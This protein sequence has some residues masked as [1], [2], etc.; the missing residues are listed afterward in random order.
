MLTLT[1]AAVD[2]VSADASKVSPLL[3]ADRLI[4]LAQDADRAGYSATADRLIRLVNR[5][6][7]EERRLAPV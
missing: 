2:G 6:F 7:D 4:T 1:D 5:V 3:I